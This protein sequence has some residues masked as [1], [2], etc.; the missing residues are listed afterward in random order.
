M[1][2]MA[3]VSF[4]SCNKN[5]TKKASAAAIEHAQ[6]LQDG[7]YELFIE[8]CVFSPDV[9]PMEVN[10]EKANFKKAMREQVH[11]VIQSKGGIKAT[12]VVSEKVSD[13]GKAATVTLNHEYNNGQNEDVVYDMVLVDD[14]WKINM[15]NHREVWRTRTADNQP[16][17]IKLKEDDHREILKERIGDERDFVKVKEGENKEVVKVKEDG[18]KDVVK[19]KEKADGDV[20]V[21]EKHDGEK[22]VV[23]VEADKK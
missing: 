1:C 6:H 3:V 11:P 20:V 2:A 13:D 4:G 12:K 17:V 18:E 22:E 16:L 8:Q 19:V 10:A 9:T 14:L 5:K 23:K 15:D 7:N 21:K